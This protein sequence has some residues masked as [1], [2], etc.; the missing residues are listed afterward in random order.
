MPHTR[1]DIN[2]AHG[3]GWL[4]PAE[5]T[6]LPPTTSTIDDPNRCGEQWRWLSQPPSPQ[7]PPESRHTRASRRVGVWLAGGVAAA[8][9]LGGAGVSWVAAPPD[10][11]TAI[12]T[13]TAASPET[14]SP[15]SGACAG[16]SGQTVTD[17]AGDTHSVAGVIA[18][19]E[20]AYYVQRRT[21]AALALVAPEAGLSV[22]ALA[23]GI[24]SIPA[25]TTHCVAITPITE[26]AA[27]VHV[28]QRHP[29]GQRVDYLQLINLRADHDH[30]VITNIQKRG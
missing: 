19:F 9:V 26:G 2:P 24:A 22:E 5:P 14:T 4:H 30:V 3:H 18:A 23:A 6:A 8:A 28:A 1:T 12:P 13:S 10:S 7:A 20:H 17:A 15:S 29:D 27:E 25:G 16:L 21:E 11:A